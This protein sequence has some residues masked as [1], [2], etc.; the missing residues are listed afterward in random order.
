MYPK[1]KLFF[2]ESSH[3]YSLIEEEKLNIKE[4]WLEQSLGITIKKNR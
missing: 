3:L 1:L 2:T 4:N